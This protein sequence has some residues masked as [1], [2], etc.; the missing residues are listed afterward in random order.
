M[1]HIVRGK[2]KHINSSVS[3]C[4]YCYLADRVDQIVNPLNSIPYILD[5]SF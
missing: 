3:K 5:N 1:K 2:I 4:F